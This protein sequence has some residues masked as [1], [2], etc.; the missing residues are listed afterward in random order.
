MK[1]SP[2]LM[3]ARSIQNLLAGRKTQTRR[4]ITRPLKHPNWTSYQYFGPSLN[5]PTCR[6]QVI[7]CGPDYPDDDTDR[8]FCPYG[9]PGD[10]LYVRETWQ[11]WND[12]PHG[13]VVVYRASCNPDGTFVFSA[14]DG[15]IEGRRVLKWRPGIHL[16]RRFSRLTLELTEVSVE[17]VQDISDADCEAEG[18]ER[19]TTPAPYRDATGELVLPYERTWRG[20]FESLWNDINGPGAW[21]RNDWT[22]ALTFRVLRENVDAVIARR[23]RLT[24]FAAECNRNAGFA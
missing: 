19:P 24:G 14:A 18:I 3:H 15:S 9:S 22:W 21:E 10:L 13:A 4:I 8:V 5:N 23:K 1:A 12:G 20:A 2:I 11:A 16:E 17:R 6:S 7:E